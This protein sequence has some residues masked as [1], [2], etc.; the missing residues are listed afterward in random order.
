MPRLPYFDMLLEQFDREH[1]DIAEKIFGRHVHYGYWENPAD[2]RGGFDD[3][4]A[5][6]EA[7]TLELCRM[8]EV[9]PGQSILDVGCGFGGTVAS[10]DE[11]HLGLAL[12]GLNID[13]R[14][15]ERA[16]SK[17]TARPG[18]TID[19][20]QG[21]ACAMPFPDASFDRVLAVECI[22][23]FPSR[24][25]FFAEAAR[26]L[27]PGGL[28]VL[29]DFVP[30]P[31]FAHVCRLARA[32]VL[33]SRFNVYGDFDTTCSFAGYRRLAAAHGFTP[34]V[35]RDASANTNPTYDFGEEL[36]EQGLSS[37]YGLALF[38]RF[39]A[40]LRFLATNGSLVYGLMSYRRA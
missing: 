36:M 16:R 9:A 12:T 27:K 4:A 40:L 23:H 39:L 32:T 29:S 33:K 19:F 2:R 37:L 25:A 6:E 3:F 28:L 21:D 34:L 10:L 31:M 15:L 30:S 11:N 13:E 7:L 18:N 17:V 22:F 5:A 1:G 26:V 38:R 14:Q 24:D 8:A 35:E 20:R